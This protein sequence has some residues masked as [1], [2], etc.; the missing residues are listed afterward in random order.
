MQ[1]R[2]H[3][4]NPDD[5]AVIRSIEWIVGWLTDRAFLGSL[6]ERPRPPE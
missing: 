3:L 1:T 5:P 4:K 2:G 6:G